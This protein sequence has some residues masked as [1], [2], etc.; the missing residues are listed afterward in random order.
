[1][2]LNY[3]YV[4]YQDSSNISK[5]DAPASAYAIP[6]YLHRGGSCGYPGG[7]N[8]M[9]PDTPEISWIE[10]TRLPARAVIRLWS[11]NPGAVE[12]APDMVFVI[13]FR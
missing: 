6:H 5:L 11:R 1:M 2:N 9:S 3:L 7:C 13:Q 10:L 8:N 4:A 12:R